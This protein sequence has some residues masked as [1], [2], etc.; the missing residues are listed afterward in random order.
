MANQIS[1]NN[2]MKEVT[3]NNFVTLEQL[4]NDN[5]IYFPL[6]K[7]NANG[8]EAKK[9][10]GKLLANNGGASDYAMPKNVIVINSDV[11]EV[12]GKVYNT[13]ANAKSYME[14]NPQEKFSVELPAGEFNEQITLSE[15]WEIHGNNTT[16]VVPIDSQIVFTNDFS[17][18]YNGFA[19]IQ[20]CTIAKGFIT[21]NGAQGIKVYIVRNCTIQRMSDIDE[22]GDP[23]KGIIV[24]YNSLIDTSDETNMNV[25]W[26]YGS[27]SNCVVKSIQINSDI[28]GGAYFIGCEV[29]NKITLING[30]TELCCCDIK[31]I[32][33]TNINAT[34]S[35]GLHNCCGFYL[36]LNSDFV[37]IENSWFEGI[38]TENISS[39]KLIQ[40][41][42]ERVIAPSDNSKSIS[43]LD[44]RNSSLHVYS[45][46][47]IVDSLLTDA[48]SKISFNFDASIDIPTRNMN[49]VYSTD[50]GASANNISNSST[51][52]THFG[53]CK[54]LNQTVLNVNNY[55]WFPISILS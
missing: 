10:L 42:I 7:N 55:I 32:D 22:S 31:N 3:E 8:T 44:V 28:Y 36:S 47:L 38:D 5:E 51:D 48:I 24:A 4:K 1:F 23:Y 11:A 17:V 15:K 39:M 21:D 2:A 35:I 29:E 25:V 26:K 54:D 16:I 14:E 52:A 41:T 40:S 37:M 49:I 6:F 46:N 19:F 27:F 13:F 43:S 53:I 18:F 30:N 12:E 50:G 45:G 33:Y 20:N 9:I 34:S